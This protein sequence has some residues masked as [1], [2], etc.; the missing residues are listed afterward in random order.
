MQVLIIGCGY[1]GKQVGASLVAAGQEVFGV[2]R[3]S[4]AAAELAPLG[5]QPVIADL[6]RSEEL[7]GLPAG[8]DGVVLCAASSG[9]GLD[10]Y[11]RVYVDG[12]R[13]VL[14]WL[15]SH[16]PR[17]LVYTGSTG[18]Y[19]QQNGEEVDEESPTEPDAPTAQILVETERM[20]REAAASGRV[21]AVMLRLAGIYGPG[22]GYWLKQFLAGEA[23]LEGD[24]SRVLNMIHRDDVARSVATALDRAEPGT[25]WNVV[26][27]EPVTQLAVFQWLAARLHAP[28]PPTAEG[29]SAGGK[30]RPGSKR[31]Q[32]RRLRQGLGVELAYPTF[33]EGFEAELRRLGR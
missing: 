30:R 12:T 27:D 14:H 4:E 15:A 6:T 23:R 24:G 22:R 9:G 25:V 26:D 33:R 31:V 17:K 11:R 32:N 2:R 1:V 29:P 18:V 13:N 19:G 8:C 10:D 21:P 5:I 16:P 20:L 3:R 7:K 28:L